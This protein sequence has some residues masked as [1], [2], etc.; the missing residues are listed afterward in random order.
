M[1]YDI[2]QLGGVPAITNI[3]ARCHHKE[4]VLV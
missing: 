4:K 3:C 1:L 2:Q